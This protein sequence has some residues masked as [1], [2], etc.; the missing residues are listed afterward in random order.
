[1]KR[2]TKSNSPKISAALAVTISIFALN[3]GSL[4]QA[5]TKT[6][7][8]A[9]TQKKDLHKTGLDLL[10]Q[11]VAK[12]SLK[13]SSEGCPASGLQKVP[14]AFNKDSNPLEIESVVADA[15]SFMEKQTAALKKDGSKCGSCQQLNVVSQASIIF[16]E[17]DK[18][19]SMNTQTKCTKYPVSNFS[20]KMASLEEGQQFIS[21]AFR[22]TSEAGEKM[23][24]ACPDPC[25]FY[26]NVA[27][28][29][30][31]GGKKLLNMTVLCGPPKVTEGFQGIDS[32]FKVSAVLI[33]EWTC[34]KPN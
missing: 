3:F 2:L 21:D 11:S 9:C 26:S 30:L 5:Q 28:T 8:S 23:F 19:V 22:G 15:N 29:N 33:H 13:P 20:K 18:S 1:M 10:S 24:A 4:V 14:L 25:S 27:L 16:P 7:D 32:P 17:I 6:C 34:A 31:A 12:H